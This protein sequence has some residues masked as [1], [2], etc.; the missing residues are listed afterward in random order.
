M[1]AGTN[2][3]AIRDRQ[4]LIA[5]AL[6]NEAGL[7]IE[8]LLNGSIFT[9]RHGEV[10]VNQV[11]GSP[12][13]GSIGNVYIRRRTRGG[14]SSFPLLGPAAP[15]RFRASE[16]QAQWDGSVDGLDY[17]CTLRLAPTQPS[18]F[19][20]LTLANATGRRLSLDAVL[21]QDLGIAHEAAV[22]S[23]ESYTSQYIDHTILEDEDLGF[24]I[25]SRQNLPQ[26]EAYP[27]VIHGC[28]AGAVGFLTDGFK[29]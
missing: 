16:D 20:T 14:I 13:E 3:W 1:T 9:I 19:W 23:S 5:T 10:L 12:V 25:C 7:A 6:R 21:A 24:L 29:L 15:S 18:W 4:K 8:L 26:G 11:L 17:S 2:S 27:W 28:L 22:R